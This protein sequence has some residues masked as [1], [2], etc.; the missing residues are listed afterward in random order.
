MSDNFR[1]FRISQKIKKIR[2]SGK[3]LEFGKIF[4]LGLV[5]IF[6]FLNIFSIAFQILLDNCNPLH[7]WIVYDPVKI[8][9]LNISER[10]WLYFN[11]Y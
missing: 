2:N 4:F 8:F 11:Y 9:R 5:N 10:F 1:Y 6:D 7:G 3:I